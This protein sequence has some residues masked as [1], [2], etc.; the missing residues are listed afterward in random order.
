MIV[1]S[2]FDAVGEVDSGLD[3]VAEAEIGWVTTVVEPDPDF[4]LDPES[5]LDGRDGAAEAEPEDKGLGGIAGATDRIDAIGFGDG[6]G[7]T[8]SPLS[9]LI[10]IALIHVDGLSA[11]LLS[12]GPTDCRSLSKV[13]GTYAS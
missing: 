4:V 5:G 3:A 13:P 10:N 6:S 12:P 11:I 7:S 2:V 9:D 8:S 1:W